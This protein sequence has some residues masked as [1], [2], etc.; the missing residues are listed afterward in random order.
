MTDDVTLSRD[1]RWLL[2]PTID[3]EERDLYV[4]D[5]VR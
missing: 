2:F 1:G 3:R 5:G 4:V